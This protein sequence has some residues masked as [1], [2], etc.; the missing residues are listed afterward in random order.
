MDLKR[1]LSLSISLALTPMAVS[2]S[3]V[4]YSQSATTISAGGFSNSLYEKARSAYDSGDVNEAVIHVKNALKQDSNNLPA[5]LLFGQILLEYG[6]LAAAEDQYRV[7]LSLNVDKS[8]VILPLAQSLLLQSK[9]SNILEDVEI[10]PYPRDINTLVYIY[11]A[12]AQS[13][14]ASFDEAKFNYEQALNLDEG[15]IDALLGLSTIAKKQNDTIKAKQYLTQAKAVAPNEPYVAFFEGE[16][17]RH[18]LKL[19]EA[20]DA[21]N[22]AIEINPNYTDARRARA[23]IYLDE[24]NLSDAQKDIEFLLEEMPDDPFSQLLHGIYLAKTNQSIEAKNLIAKTSERFSQLDPETIDQFAPLAL[25]YGFSQFLQG[26]LQNAATSLNNYLQK[27]PSSK[28]AREILAEIAIERRQYDLASDLLQPIS[29]SQLSKRSAHIMLRSLIETQRFNQAL[30]LITALPTDITQTPEMVNLHA[31]V[32]VKSGKPDQAISLLTQQNVAEKGLAK[33]QT[34]LILGYNYLNL[35]FNNEALDIANQLVSP[36]NDNT[37]AE[38]NYIASAYLVNQDDKN[39]ERYF[40]KALQ[41]DK[42]DEVVKRNLAQLHL[43]NGQYAKSQ[44]LI[45]E[46]LA[47]NPDNLNVL[48]IYGELLKRQNDTV[49]SLSVFEQINELAPQ[50][51]KNKYQLANAYLASQQADKAI[52][53]ANDI[54]R[55]ESLSPF[56]LIVKAKANLL[57]NDNAQAAR[58]L[59]IAF[60]LFTEDADKLAEIAKLQ[61]AAAD[62]LSVEKAILEIEKLSPNHKDLHHIRVRLLEATGDLNGALAL[63]Q[64]QRKKTAAFYALQA[65]LMLKLYQDQGALASAKSAYEMEPTIE[66]HELL[67][68]TLLIN[69]DN[70]GAYQQFDAWLTNNPNDWQTWRK[71]ASLYEQHDILDDAVEHYERAIAINNKDTFSLNNLSLLLIEKKRYAE[72]LTYA[73][74]AHQFA[75]LEAKINDTLGWALVHENREQEAINY[76]RESLARDHNNATTRFHLGM[77]LK[78]LNRNDE[79]LTELYQALTASPNDEMKALIQQAIDN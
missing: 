48:P 57:K 58:S 2:F 76:F 74:Q 17:F 68:R 15:N 32:L 78:R 54:N 42:D 46:M 43:K 63:L 66:H 38:L 12:K 24:N 50:N 56:A 71:V 62:F 3:P 14:L 29:V 75:P 72:A 7:A 27:N 61:L 49:G 35:G 18:E 23:T 19:A 44:A 22:R 13:G 69:R 4:T 28:Q 34:L 26:N 70:V 39:A 67:I 77:A 8:L 64:K 65:N 25:V 9:F 20:L 41:L 53:T 79:A 73:Q 11:R 36:S 5:R 51:L 55:L 45:E 10:G 6:E 33:Q 37:I 59:R 40:Y 52:N 31:V 1:L 16:Q 30:E 60:G 47:L 21:Y